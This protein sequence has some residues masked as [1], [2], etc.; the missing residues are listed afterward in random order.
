MTHGDLMRL[1]LIEVSKHGM[2]WENNTGAALVG[3]RYIRFGLKGSSDILACV[4]KIFVGIEVKVGRDRTSADQK[5][6]GAALERAGGIY[7]VAR[8]VED[9]IER[10]KKEKIL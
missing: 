8:S 3:G 4:K 7:I 2:C 5:K 1:I 6:F 9:V 10:L